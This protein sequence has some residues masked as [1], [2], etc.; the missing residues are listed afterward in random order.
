[1]R[2]AVPVEDLLLLLCSYA[3]V[4]VQEV[5]ESALGFFERGIG[6]RLQVSQ[7]GEDALLELLR[8]L[9]WTSEC[10]ESEG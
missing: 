5:E 10:L 6:T 4:L 1:M 9:H 3:V 8:V 2:H 7:I